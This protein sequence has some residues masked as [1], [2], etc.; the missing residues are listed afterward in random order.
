MINK[1]NKYIDEK[2][3][4]I[5]FLISELIKIDSQ[6]SGIPNSANE[7]EVQHYVK[8]L[9]K[10][11]GLSVNEYAFDKEKVRPNVLGFYKGTGGGKSLLINAHADTISITSPEKWKYPPLGGIIENG[12]V[13][14]R[15]ASDDKMAIVAMIFALKAI[16]ENGI[17]LKG[18]VMLLSSVGEESG[19]GA[20]IGAGSVMKMIDKP[21][22]A[23]VSE[24]TCMEIDITSSSLTYFEIYIK[25]KPAHNMGRNQILFPQSYSIPTGNEVAVDAL[26]KALLVIDSLYRLERDLC[27]NN[28]FEVWGAGGTPTQDERGVGLFT[29]NPAIISGG[30]SI[31][32]IME[33]V[34][35]T[36]SVY[37]PNTM[38][39]E[40]LKNIINKQI[41]SVAESDIWLRDNPPELKMPLHTVW[42]GFATEKDHPG[43]KA[44][45]V[46][47]KK[48]L[49]KEPIITGNKS[50]M[51][52]SFIS[53]AGIPVVACGPGG[54]ETNQHGIDEFCELH[55]VL[56]SIKVY[57]SM[58]IEWC[59]VES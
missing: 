54:V 4:E 29:I 18:N 15:G 50:V 33:D 32:S 9:M 5:A 11:V 13:Y 40:E 23:L 24:S 31:A 52:T 41:L 51:D 25:G 56:K 16:L 36:Y 6:N 28:K 14:G 43:V 59:G 57:A 42:P 34:T 3:D 44:L 22:F 37:Y 46:A 55:E 19:E 2:E 1:I 47:Y 58:M 7:S 21:D 27:L 35:I 10:K 8:D 49:S 30:K 12:R 45:R 48:A 17:N 39:I 26:S 38:N 20:T 53:A